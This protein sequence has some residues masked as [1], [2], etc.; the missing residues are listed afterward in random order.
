MPDYPSTPDDDPIE[1]DPAKA[2]AKRA[3]DAEK[4]R[5][6]FVRSQRL[7][8]AAPATQKPIPAPEDGL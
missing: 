2:K 3:E 5:Q 4:I 6:D 8:S 1:F 7:P